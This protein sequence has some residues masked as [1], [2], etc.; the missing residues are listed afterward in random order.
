M[1]NPKMLTYVD[2]LFIPYIVVRT[3]TWFGQ[4]LA[5]LGASNP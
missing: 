4:L 5:T 3:Q 2:L 1:H